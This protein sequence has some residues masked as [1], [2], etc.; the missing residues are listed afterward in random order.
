[1]NTD[2]QYEIPILIIGFNRPDVIRQTFEYVKAAK[3]TKL[4]IAIDGARENRP[5]EEKLVEE[6]KQVFN[7]IDWE[8]EVHKKY[9]TQN[10]GAEV[11]VSS[12][13]TWALENEE[14]AIVLEDDIVASKAF[15]QFAKDMLIRY[16]DC[17]NVYLVSG[18]NYTPTEFNSKADYTY[19]FSGHT[20]CGWATW[21]RAWDKFTLNC[22][23]IISK[24]ELIERFSTKHMANI[25]YKG[26]KKKAMQPIGSCTWDVCWSFIRLK[27]KG[28]SIVPRV[29]L[30]SNIGVYGLHDNGQT[31]MHFLRYDNDFIAV[32]HPA[33]ITI[34]KDYDKYHFYKYMYKPLWK[35][36]IN[37]LSRIFKL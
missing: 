3:P 7:G 32:N 6:V 35:K 24:E 13:V 2:M 12:A 4:Y 27:N 36:V 37:R 21:K 10:L 31:R 33:K 14:Y 34:D 25:K 16:K 18:G 11:T 26:L 20:G 15:L 28:L 30:T 17:E 1:M 23:F 19:C 22:D 5:G 8:C 9:N 29:N